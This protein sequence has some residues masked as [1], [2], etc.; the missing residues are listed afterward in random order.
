[1]QKRFQSDRQQQANAP[2]LR[3]GNSGGA[4]QYEGD[5]S[6][7]SG[8]GKELIAHAIHY[9]SSRKDHPFVKVNCA[10]LYGTH[11]ELQSPKG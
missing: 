3:K 4:Y 10:A 11:P 7:E 6:G 1:M 8:T 9:N 5:D 2:G